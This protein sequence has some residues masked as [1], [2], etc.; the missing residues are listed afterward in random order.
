M[1]MMF[2]RS[3]SYHVD[4][5]LF[6]RA[7]AFFETDFAKKYLASSGSAGGLLLGNRKTGKL[8]GISLWQGEA[9]MNATEDVAQ[10]VR[11]G[12]QLAGNGTD[13]IVREDWVVL[14]FIAPEQPK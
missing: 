13:P 11:E 9:D 1:A 4:P 12:V 14:S 5:A 3:G 2:A 10:Q 6:D 8:L 7:L